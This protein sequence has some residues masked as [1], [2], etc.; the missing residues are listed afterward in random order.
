M[1]PIIEIRSYNLKPGTGEAFN[2][3]FTNE[4]LPLLLKWGIKVVSHG[5]SLHNSD[6]YF[7]VRSFNGVEERQQLED[8]FYGSKEW[9]E[10]PREA[11]LSLIENF[12][13]LV[14]SLNSIEKMSGRSVND[15]ENNMNIK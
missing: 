15:K 3:L 5:P 4:A 10:G 2:Q 9:K 6:S 7:L 13:T 11:I 8:E 14:L 12:A 1:N